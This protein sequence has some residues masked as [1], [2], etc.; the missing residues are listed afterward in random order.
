MAAYTAAG[1]PAHT[2]PPYLGFQNGAWRLDARYVEILTVVDRG[3]EAVVPLPGGHAHFTS[4]PAD[5]ITALL[6]TG[7]TPPTT[8][9]GGLTMRP[10]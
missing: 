5:R 9:I 4:G 3:E 10:L 7:G 6:L 1:F 8:E 2:D